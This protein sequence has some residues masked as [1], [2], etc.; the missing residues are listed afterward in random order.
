VHVLVYQSDERQHADIQ[1]A[2][3]NIFDLVAYLNQEGIT[4]SLAHPIWAMNNRLTLAH[5]EQLLLL[6]KNFELNG[7]RDA[8][9][10]DWLR[11]ILSIL[12]PGD[13]DKMMEIYQVTPPFPTP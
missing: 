1:K 11:I 9:L 4:L 3:T 10:N 8:R 2:R 5:F 7:A 13:M 12:S 6:F